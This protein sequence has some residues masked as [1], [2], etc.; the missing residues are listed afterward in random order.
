MGKIILTDFKGLW[1]RD[2]VE[3]C[4]PDH[5]TD[6]LNV[7]FTSGGVV[8]RQAIDRVNFIGGALNGVAGWDDTG[9]I[10]TPIRAIEL[11][12]TNEGTDA[13][14]GIYGNNFTRPIFVWGAVLADPFRFGGTNISAGFGLVTDINIVSMN[15]RAYIGWLQGELAYPGGVVHVYNGIAPTIGGSVFRQIGGTG[16]PSAIAASTA[17]GGNAVPNSYYHY[18]IGYELDTGHI[19][20]P[21][22]TFATNIGGGVGTINFQDLAAAPAN[23]VARWW[24]ISK[25]VPVASYV[26]GT[27]PLYMAARVAVPTATYSFSKADSELVDSADWIYNQLTQIPIGKMMTSYN[28]RLVIFGPDGDKNLIYVSKQNQPE[29]FN[30]TSGFR[31]IDITDPTGTKCGIEWRGQLYVFTGRRTAALTDTG[32]EVTTWPL[33]IIDSA[34]GALGHRSVARVL[35]VTRA[36]D[37]GFM[38]ASESG[39]FF[40]NGAYQRPELTWKIEN[41]WKR[42]NPVAKWLVALYDDPVSQVLYC[43][44]PLD[45]STTI[46]YVLVGDYKDGLNAQAIKWSLNQYLGIGVTGGMILYDNQSN[47]FNPKGI[48]TL[49]AVGNYLMIV[50]KTK[51]RD[52]E[53]GVPI[54]DIPSYFDLPPARFGDGI[55]HF[56]RMRLRALG[57]GTVRFTPRIQDL[58]SSGP[59]VS[60]PL[61]AAP[62]R[63]YAYLINHVNE[64]LR[65]RAEAV[66]AT[67]FDIRRVQLEGD[68]I[69]DERPR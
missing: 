9:N 56:N 21:T 64:E 22:I 35:D 4:P 43:L 49:M 23:T 50:D 62:G 6:C 10:G 42:I 11:Y 55:S 52:L 28:G 16:T 61:A 29:S 26:G 58:V 31:S 57:S 7:G 12:K 67:K 65:L 60:H 34:I 46:N 40:F 15:S 39:I 44:L 18:T 68:L 25:S 38:I 36:Q 47:Y 37:T 54:T 8:P 69:W 53:S 24:L 45:A 32:G 5:F 63:E 51:T 59:V 30:A 14:S 17:A 20:K 48:V 3:S 19:L 41:I 2:P 13:A 1:A 27:L 66:G 33:N